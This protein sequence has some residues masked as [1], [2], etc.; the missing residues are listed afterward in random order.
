MLNT[1]ID[2]FFI[3]STIGF[4]IMWAL[5]V[6]FLVYLIKIA[7]IFHSISQNFKHKIDTFSDSTQEIIDD[8]Q[9]SS[10]YRLFFGSKTKKK[11]AQKSN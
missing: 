10:F 1:P 9:K 8:I 5:F 4:I 11:T 3:I 2:L 7:R 6:V